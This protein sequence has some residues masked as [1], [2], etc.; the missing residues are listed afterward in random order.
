VIGQTVSHYTILEQLGS[1]GMGVV[2]KAED[3]RL[4]RLVA[5]KFLPPELTRDPDAKERFIREAQAASALQHANICVIHDI[6]QTDDGRMFMCMELY[7]GE[8]LAAMIQKGPLPLQA[9]VDIGITVAKGLACA[10]EAGIVHRDVKPGNVFVTR[11]GDVK[12]LDFGLAKT[13]GQTLLTGNGTTL[14]TVAYMSPEQARAELVDR[15]TDIWAIGAILYEMMTGRTPFPTTYAPATLYAIINTDPEPVTAL[16]SGVPMKL[17][18]VVTK[19][20]SKDPNQRYQHADDL[21]TDLAAVGRTLQTGE[22]RRW[23]QQGQPVRKASHRTII[24][25]SI[26]TLVVALAVIGVVFLRPST[27]GPIDSVAVLPLTNFSGDAAQEYFSDG[28]TEAI[29][30]ELSTVK[31]LR[32]ISRTSVMAFKHTTKKLPDIAKELNVRAVIEGS[33]ARSGESVRISVQLIGASPERHLWANTFD[34]KAQDILAL[35]RDVARAI[36]REVRVAVSPD[37]ERRMSTTSHVDPAAHDAYLKALAY[38]NQFSEAGFTTAIEYLQKAISIDSNYATAY[39]SLG[40]VYTALIVYGY[41]WLAPREGWPMVKALGAKALDKDETDAEA[42]AILG[43]EAYYF[44]WDAGT[45]EQQYRRALELNP[46]SSMCH[47]IY[48][49]FLAYQG[50]IPEALAETRRALELDPLS[51][52]FRRAEASFYYLSRAY[53]SAEVKLKEVIALQ[54]GFAFAHRVLAWVHCAQGRF[55]EAIDE[56][57]IYVSLQPGDI[58]GQEL[59]CQV[60]AA[61]GRQ[62]QA[63]ELLRR[64]LAGSGKKYL[65]TTWLA[66]VYGMLGDSGRAFE[67]LEKAYEERN[68]DLVTLRVD[69]QFDVLRTDK[70]FTTFLTRIAPP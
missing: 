9:A 55:D 35:Q 8:T 49:N 67:W 32:V 70:R 33:V 47:L 26:A 69:P 56:A 48:G 37:E 20:L 43:E 41:G 3:T 22:T 68:V 29:I 13:A 45:A 16:R 59:L 34:S 21:A 7:E 23:S 42:H 36:V 38:A 19:A 11:R 58:Q 10:H 25:A 46:G 5:L 27:S 1:G 28:M 65:S 2:Y 31:A 14:G 57:L 66:R 17:E 12:I 24:I 62:P 4:K 44:A 51:L 39:S 64:L 50:R 54:P 61:S 52:E 40:L 18:Q 15:R 60:Y 63:Q 30:A 53:D 6:D